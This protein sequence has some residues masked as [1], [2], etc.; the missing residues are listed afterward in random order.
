ME[1]PEEA[2]YTGLLNQQLENNLSSVRI[3][4]KAKGQVVW[5]VKAKHEDPI[6]A[7]T[8]AQKIF[9]ELQRKYGNNPV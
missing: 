5:E 3:E 8:E 7:S 9:D 6:K 4:T 1:T 2:H